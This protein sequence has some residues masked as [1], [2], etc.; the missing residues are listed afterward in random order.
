[1]PE[2]ALLM[3]EVALLMLELALGGSDTMTRPRP[4]GQRLPDGPQNPLDQEL[5]TIKVRGRGA[6]LPDAYP[7]PQ[8][9]WIYLDRAV[10]R[11]G[12]QDVP[13]PLTELT[14]TEAT[15]VAFPR[16]KRKAADAIWRVRAWGPDTD[17]ESRG[18]RVLLAQLG[19]LAGWPAPGA[20]RTPA[21]SGHKNGG[22][23]VPGVTRPVS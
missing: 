23:L 6:G 8:V 15:R 12:L 3:L 14:V 9:G 5:G 2:S 18:Y 4:I 7:S 21:P 20:D 22:G 10:V 19:T 13:L 11:P 1:M 16:T 17:V